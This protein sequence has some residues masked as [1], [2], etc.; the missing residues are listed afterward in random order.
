MSFK[1]DEKTPIS[2]GPWGGQNGIRWDDGVYSTVRQL[3][4]VHGAGI[5]S[6]QI[7]YD[8][9][10]SSVWSERHGGNGGS[11]TSKV[12][13]D[14]PDEFLTSIHG[15]YGGLNEWGRVFIRSLTFESN[16]K[17][18]G[19][20]GIEEGTY[21]S[22]PMSGGKIV[23]F[24][25]KCSWYLDAIGAY[26]KPLNDTN[27][28]RPL[29]HSQSYVTNG[30]EKIGYSIV[31]GSVGK[32]YDIV[33]AVRQKED[34]SNTLSSTLSRKTSNSQEFS[35]AEPKGKMLATERVPSKVDGL[36]TYGPWGGNGGTAFQDG[37]YTGV[38]QINLSR[39]VG[40][41]SIKVLYEQDGQAIW[42]NKHGG[43]GGF[44]HDKV[45]CGVV[46]EPAPCGPGLGLVSCAHVPNVQHGLQ[47]KRSCS[48]RCPMKIDCLLA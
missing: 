6:I 10:G 17:T 21:F 8:K 42:G 3:V 12:N 9:K 1:N 43:S 26:L 39:N 41:V 37:I 2:V 14:Y 5:D 28:S 7:E 27:P 29:V 24:H 23:G 47:N 30:T 4:I 20:F 44:K 16:R 11:K 38:R 33:L 35:D 15:Y 36:V 48:F 25:G 34:Y 31:Q 45:A 40:I 13:L 46:K 32:S 18:Y 19:P 22:F